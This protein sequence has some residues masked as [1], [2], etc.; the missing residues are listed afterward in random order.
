MHKTININ[1]NDYIAS[2][3]LFEYK[4][5]PYRL[6]L[7]TQ[8]GALLDNNSYLGV[9]TQMTTLFVVL[10]LIIVLVPMLMAYYIRHMLFKMD[11]Q[12]DTID[13]VNRRLSKINQKLMESDLHDTRNNL[14]KQKAIIP[15]LEKIT[16]REIYPVTFIHIKCRNIESRVKFIERA[17][18]ILDKNVLRFEYGRTDLVLIFIKIDEKRALDKINILV[19]D[20]SSVEN[21]QLVNN[22]A[23]ISKLKDRYKQSKAV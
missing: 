6:C 2:G 18:Y 23:D 4:N 21:S 17:V 1:D 13:T 14:W 8:R 19:D 10:L 9:K 7:L 3:V 15:F 22:E 12:K 5:E 16:K 11:V 20:N